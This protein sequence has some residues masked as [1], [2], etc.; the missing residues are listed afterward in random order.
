MSNAA[1]Y[2]N[3]KVP[4]WAVQQSCEKRTTVPGL[5]HNPVLS[6]DNYCC[7]GTY[8]IWDSPRERENNNYYVKI[9]DW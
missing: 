4:Q 5:V 7:H 6:E 1:A 3:Y 9:V 2:N 8:K